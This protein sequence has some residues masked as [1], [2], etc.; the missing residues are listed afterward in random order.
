[1]KDFHHLFIN[2]LKS[3]YSAEEQLIKAIPEMAK[4][5]STDKLKEALH[6]HHLETKNQLKRLEAISFELKVKLTGGSCEV[7]KTL[8][9]EGHKMIKAGYDHM[10]KDAAIINCA[11]RIEHYEISSYGILKCY[12]KHFKLDAVED[13]LE[14]TS[15]E[16]G[17]AD[18]KLT[19]IAEGT[20]FDTGVNVKAYKRCA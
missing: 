2:E 11:Q 15:K 5:A 17:R 16:E 18:K 13:L 12:A 7:M 3:I 4:A 10:T 1:M 9:K 6:H 14:A 8:I 19:E 20:I